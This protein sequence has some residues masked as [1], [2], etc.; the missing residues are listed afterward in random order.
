MTFSRSNHAQASVLNG[1][2]SFT[3]IWSYASKLSSV[4]FLYFSFL[5][6]KER[7]TAGN[8]RP[9]HFPLHFRMSR[10]KTAQMDQFFVA[11]SRRID[12][13][14]NSAA[15]NQPGRERMGYNKIPYP[16]ELAILS[17]ESEISWGRFEC[18]DILLTWLD[19]GGNNRAEV[20]YGG[21]W[22]EDSQDIL[23]NPGAGS[24]SSSPTPQCFRPGRCITNYYYSYYYLWLHICKGKKI[25][26]TKR[27]CIIPVSN[28]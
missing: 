20:V 27:T 26:S 6:N 17:G 11:N 28:E 13:A 7:C 8:T 10:L 5:W 16:F 15:L 9:T 1:E 22:F 25:Q 3:K 21:V 24:G 4:F 18:V 12:H 19:C 14:Y 23:H 2:S